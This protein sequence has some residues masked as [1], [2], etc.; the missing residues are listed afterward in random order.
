MTAIDSVHYYVDRE[1]KYNKITV[2]VF[3]L[4]R[5]THTCMH[6]D[7]KQDKT[8]DNVDFC[9]DAQPLSRYINMQMA[10]CITR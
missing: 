9:I 6:T 2:I 4:Q 5:T 7:D 10:C 8:I 3:Q 1:I